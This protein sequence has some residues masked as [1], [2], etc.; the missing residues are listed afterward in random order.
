MRTHVHAATGISPTATSIQQPRATG[1]PTGCLAAYALPLPFPFDAARHRCLERVRATM[2][3]ARCVD[4]DV[5]VGK[6]VRNRNDNRNGGRNLVAAHAD[7]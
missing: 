1:W 5:A 7:G 6:P 3:P 4:L 2:E